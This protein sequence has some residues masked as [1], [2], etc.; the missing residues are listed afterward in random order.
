MKNAASIVLAT[1]GLL[2]FCT[3]EDVAIEATISGDKLTITNI[4]STT[5]YYF[6]VG[7]KF[8]TA[9]IWVPTCTVDNKL[10]GKKT[11]TID[12]ESIG[13]DRNETHIIIYYWEKESNGTMCASEIN[14]LILPL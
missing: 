14:N 4:S 7:Q 12:L 10:R 3:N 13:K 6:V 8:A 2:L 9:I 5:C 1:F 11:V